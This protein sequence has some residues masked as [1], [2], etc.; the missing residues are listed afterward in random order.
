MKNFKLFTI[1]VL[2][3]SASFLT[4]NAQ[5]YQ[6]WVAQYSG[7]YG[8]SDYINDL[9]VRDGYVYVTGYEGQF[10]AYWATVK[11]DY[12]GQEQ[13]VQRLVD[14]QSQ[15]AEA[16]AVDAAGNVYVTGYQYQF[17][18]SGDVATLKYSPNGDSLWKQL[19]SS[20]GGNNQPNDIALDALGNIYITGAS[21]VTAQEDFDLLLLKYDP[22]GNLLWDR[23]LDNGDGQLDSGYK[24][25]IDP[26]GNAIVAG[27]T[28]PNPYLVKYSP[29]G[30][31]LWEDEHVGFSTNDEWK[32]V[33]TD[34]Q[35]NIYVL[36]EISP[37]G[38]SNH[39]W[40]A[41]YDPDGNILWEDNYTGTADESCYAG[42][43]A[44]MPDGGVVVSGQSWDLPNNNNIITIRYAPDGT[45]LWQR[46]ETA[47]YAHAS[48]EDVAADADGNIY[49]TGYGF[50]YTY[51][52]DIITLGYSPDGDLLWTQIYAGP[53]PNQSDY[54]QA[55]AVDEASNVFVA[56]TSWYPASSADYI[57]IMYSPLPDVTIALTP[58]GQPIQIPANGGSFDFNIA[59]TN[60][61]LDPVT[62][63]V[64]T[65]ATLPNGSEVGPIILVE[66]ITIPA[67]TT[68]D[69]DRT[70]AVPAGAPAGIY[71][72][73]A[74]I[75]DYDAALWGEDHFDFEKLATG[76]GSVV[77][78]WASWG[79]EFDLNSSNV[80]IETPDKFALFGAYP[81]PFN[82]TTTLS[83]QL[84]VDSKVNLTVFDV[85]GRQV[86]ELVNG[87]RNAG[88]HTIT[89]NA[90]DLTSG[91]YFAQLSFNGQS[92][93]QKLM[94]IK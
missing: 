71:T 60:N 13:W 70:Q 67:E 9:E 24:L 94:L 28:E 58:V 54:P 36:G 17:S 77:Y 30:D 83:F 20:P 65:M 37:P 26:D 31:L 72:Y 92:Q 19:Y 33:V 57:T 93:V 80:K 5:Y 62:M 25:A 85:N 15:T 69:R 91:I 11:Y 86:A 22:D 75:G 12:S 8:S 6:N 7:Q 29:T 73:D 68:I 16:L 56:A 48:G 35:G 88:N 1:I 64:W 74:Y 87:Y 55:I 51:W 21:W 46:L 66:D 59:V 38:E 43:L 10:T 23:T 49:V 78:G 27:Y 45:E 34:A 32:R 2:L 89:F 4:A 52:E 41:K 50:N 3:I 40:T 90:S 47:G 18:G 81:N 39:L 14:G 42:G 44:L 82:P 79:E 53:E 84:A 76:D 61:E 63:D